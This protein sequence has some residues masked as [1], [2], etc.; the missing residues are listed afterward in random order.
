MDCNVS[1]IVIY[2][3][4]RFFHQFVIGPFFHRCNVES[5]RD[6]VAIAAGT[7][8]T[9]GLY[10]DGTVFAVGNN[11]KGQCDVGQWRDV[12]AIAAGD[13]N[14]IG[15]RRDG[16]LLATGSNWMGKSNVAKLPGLFL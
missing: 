13:G 14:T 5:W 3:P 8:H 1:Y 9:V 16:R 11:A 12:I 4:L 6:I 10:K 15:L 2:Q 7:D